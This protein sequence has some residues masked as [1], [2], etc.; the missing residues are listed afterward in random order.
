MKKRKPGWHNRTTGLCLL[1]ALFCLTARPALRAA[2]NANPSPAVEA[3]AAESSATDERLRQRVYVHATDERI[4]DVLTGLSKATGV[5]LLARMEV[6][7]ERVSLWAED[8]TLIEVMRDLRHLRGYFWSREKRGDNY[9]YALWQDAQSR[10]REEAE[11][12]RLAMEQQREFEQHIWK[13]V[14]ALNATD[15]E[16]KQMAR[17]DPYLVVQMKHPVVRNGFQL[18]AALSPDQ[19]ALLTQGRTP[20]RSHSSG[21]I[22]QVF[23]L[24]DQKGDPYFN[25]REWSA[26]WGPRGDVVALSWA[27]MTPAQQAAARAILH[28]AAA[29][30][31]EEAARER[32]R[33]PNGPNR[34]ASFEWQAPAVAAAAF[35]TATATFFRSGDPSSL[36]LSFRLDFQSSGRGWA[37]YSNI[38]TQGRFYNEMLQKGEGAIVPG[39]SPDVAALLRDVLKPENRIAPAPAPPAFD[40]KPDPVL[41]K[42]L[43]F[44]WSLPLREW[45]RKK[46]YALNGHEVLAALHREIRRPLVLDGL[47]QWLQK[48]RSEG[49][50]FQWEKRSVRELLNRLFPGMEGH[51]HGG[52]LFLRNP[53]RLR[54][55]LHQ[56]PPAVERYL[57]AV[58]GSFTLDDMAL[59]ARSLSPWQI[60]NL[61]Y[62]RY[63]PDDA[64]DQ[65]LA[66]QELLKLY[67]ELS[68]EQRAAL[69]QGLPFSALTP[70]Q[71]ALFLQ[72]AQRYRP[73]VELWRLQQGRLAVTVGPAPI[74]HDGYGGPAAKVSRAVIQVRFGERDAQS[75][76]LDL[77]P[78]TRRAS[79]R[80]SA[81]TL[82][83]KPF[84]GFEPN[85]RIRS[86]DEPDPVWQ[87]ALINPRLQNRTAVIMI[88][89]P[90]AEPHVG[91]QPPPSSITWARA[92]A[93]RLDGAGIPVAHLT[94]GPREKVASPAEATIRNSQSAVRTPEN[95]LLFWEPGT[96]NGDPFSSGSPGDEVPQSPTVFVVDRAGI[97]RAVFEGMHAWDVPAVERAVRELGPSPGQRQTSSS[98][99]APR[100]TGHAR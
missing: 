43:T 97:V 59:L 36:S 47:P 73:Y 20:S 67:S 74:K 18:F 29:R 61:A 99:P 31:R 54:Q 27:E 6:A 8:R 83:G 89:R 68:P 76:P 4:A 23:P 38:G 37:I 39:F 60:V 92:L 79:R 55:R 52:A 82:V 9:V 40:G 30:L 71:Q 56:V 62:L 69:P 34:A 70:P 96:I 64:I 41:D 46:H 63:L 87:P 88:A 19:Q 78:S 57:D 51:V 35:D 66:T 91:T 42:P 10:A 94:V 100:T 24:E 11:L 77:F 90:Y 45:I 95:L 75:F 44:T 28:G 72:F 21:S 86:S 58:K 50:Y 1:S 25:P 12:Q 14:K 17:E 85:S 22:M 7:D 26:E 5:T 98:A 93:A 32:Q 81:S 65:T 53:D 13:R 80:I 2:E 84:P 16:L 3:P 15:E 48:E 33:S 49:P